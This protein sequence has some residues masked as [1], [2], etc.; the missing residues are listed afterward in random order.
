MR[1]FTKRFWAWGRSR[2]DGC[3]NCCPGRVTN[4]GFP[5]FE[6]KEYLG[7]SGATDDIDNCSSICWN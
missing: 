4:L 6:L 1:R 2:R 7:Q 3:G 5:E